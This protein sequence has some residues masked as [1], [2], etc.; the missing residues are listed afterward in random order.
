[1]IDHKVGTPEEWAAA[2]DDLLE[3]EKELTRMSDEGDAFQTWIR[4]H[5]EHVS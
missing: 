1:M 5:D 4:R 3:R 2:R